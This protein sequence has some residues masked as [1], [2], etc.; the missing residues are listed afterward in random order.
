MQDARFDMTVLSGG[1]ITIRADKGNNAGEVVITNLPLQESKLFYAHLQG[2]EREWW[3]KKRD[4]ELEEKRAAAGG[5]NI[6]MAAAPNINEPAL[7]PVDDIE[8]KLLKLKGLFEKGLI[9][10]SEYKER[11]SQ[12]LELL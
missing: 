12:L 8:S 9:D 6:S 5:T 11:K 3:E 1:T 2:I 7:P 10:A 4:L